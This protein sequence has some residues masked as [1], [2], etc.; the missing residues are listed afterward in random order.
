[1][2]ASRPAGTTLAFAVVMGLVWVLRVALEF[3][4]PVRVRIFMLPNTPPCPDAVR[5]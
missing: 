1:M 3:Q 5:S 2:P 4:Y